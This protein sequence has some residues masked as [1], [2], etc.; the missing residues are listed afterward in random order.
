M[1]IRHSII[2]LIYNQE[3]FVSK[4][5]ESV[6]NQSVLPYEIIVGDDCSTDNSSNIINSYCER[7]P[8]LIKF[9][10]QPKNLGLYLH[11]NFLCSKVCGDVISILGGDDFL[12]GNMLEEFNNVILKNDLNPDSD[13]FI[14]AANHW[15]LQK[16]GKMDVF[17]NSHVKFK[18]LF[19]ERLRYG[20][21][22]RDSGLSRKLFDCLE[23]VDPNLGIIAD[24]FWGFDQIMNCDKFILIPRAFYVYR[25]GIGE[26]SRAGKIGIARSGL[27]IIEVVERKYPESIKFQDS[28]FINFLKS[29]FTFEINGNFHSHLKFMFWTLMNFWNFSRGNPFRNNLRAFSVIL[30]K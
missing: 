26:S 8:T 19:A 13:R 28:L 14:L 10:K 7:F 1:Q 9:Y 15:I 20:V 24:W 21:S 6:I 4:C 22:F 11:L 29:K 23:I 16:N 5:L 12:S 2:I 18:N 25:S 17:D 30:K 3:E 27:R